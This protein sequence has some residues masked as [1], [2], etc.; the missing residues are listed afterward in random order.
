[1]LKREEISKAVIEYCENT[2]LESLAY[3]NHQT[4][5]GRDIHI[6]KDTYGFGG[7]K[8]GNVYLFAVV[9]N[10]AQT[11]YRKRMVVVMARI[12]NEITNELEFSSVGDEFFRFTGPAMVSYIQQEPAPDNSIEQYSETSN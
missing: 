11:E 10:W 9:G 1:M 7:S 6:L 3:W 4:K 12:V 5:G 2:M 8:H